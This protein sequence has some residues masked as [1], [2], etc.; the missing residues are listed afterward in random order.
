MI[1]GNAGK[2]RVALAFLLGSAAAPARATEACIVDCLRWKSAA[3]ARL[4]E[5]CRNVVDPIKAETGAHAVIDCWFELEDGYA[6]GLCSHVDA[7]EQVALWRREALVQGHARDEA[8][9]A[10]R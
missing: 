7:L 2:F 1:V 8:R 4:S 9:R 6:A 3:P 10:V 5:L